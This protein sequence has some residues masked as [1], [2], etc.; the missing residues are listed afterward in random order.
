MAAT[1]YRVLFV[2]SLLLTTI[3]IFIWHK[4]LDVTF[5]MVYTRGCKEDLPRLEKYYAGIER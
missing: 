2:L 1:Y 4:H 5:A 3:Y